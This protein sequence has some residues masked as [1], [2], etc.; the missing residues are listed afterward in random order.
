MSLLAGCG[1]SDSASTA[2]ERSDAERPDSVPAYEVPLGSYD[3]QG[4]SL[5]GQVELAGVSKGELRVPNTAVEILGVALTDEVSMAKGGS[6][7]RLVAPRGA[8]L[9]VAKV[10][11]QAMDDTDVTPQY[12]GAAE[13]DGA[14]LTVTGAGI[15]EELLYMQS[16]LEGEPMWLVHSVPTGDD[17]SIR[18][19][20]G[21]V[22]QDF[23]LQTMGRREAG[24]RLL[25]SGD[26][27]GYQADI[28]AKAAVGTTYADSESG[29]TE[30]EAFELNL[31]H[32]A[33]SPFSADDDVFTLAGPDEAYLTLTVTLGRPEYADGD[34]LFKGIESS[35]PPSAFAVRLEDGTDIKAT[36]GFSVVTEVSRQQLAFTVP[37]DFA[38]GKI[39]LSPPDQV[40]ARNSKDW[41]T[42]VLRFDTGPYEVAFTVRD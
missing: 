16:A 38:A 41:I 33:L 23:D 1:S 7:S 37:A 10:Q 9:L 32:A 5:D 31:V 15:D 25:Y 42:G 11:V 28:D 30:R 19:A 13:S 21:G 6:P 40:D 39:V 8:K 22:T 20:N 24:S 17:L 26:G 4:G 27:I 18:L 29:N 35:I 2:P 3:L 14:K 36:E 34:N 12:Q